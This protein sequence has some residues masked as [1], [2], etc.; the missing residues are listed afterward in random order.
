MNEMNILPIKP[1]G[2]GRA[3]F[4]LIVAINGPGT[5]CSTLGV[6]VFGCVFLSLD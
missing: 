3:T 1:R 6:F 5:G 2:N 4:V